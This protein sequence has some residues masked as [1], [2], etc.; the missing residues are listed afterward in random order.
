R[1]PGE[2]QLF[3]GL[4][5]AASEGL[6]RA[7]QMTHFRGSWVLVTLGVA[8]GLVPGRFMAA[9][10]REEEEARASKAKE[11]VR[12]ALH[13]E[14]DGRQRDRNHLLMEAIQASPETAAA[15]WHAGYV[16]WRGQWVAADKVPGLIERDERLGA[17]LHQRN[18]AEETVE[19]QLKLAAFCERKGLA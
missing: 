16:Q 7:L 19:G 10:T 13:A 8:L 1:S 12:E 15:R 3:S 5:W 11:L 6:R 9:A 18:K 4:F 2:G 17:Y 14:L